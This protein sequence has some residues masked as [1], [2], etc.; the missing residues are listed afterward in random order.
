MPYQRVEVL[1]A[2]PTV[3]TT[4]FLAEFAKTLRADEHAVMVLDCAA[5]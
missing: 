1:S 5:C 2:V 4:R 3:T